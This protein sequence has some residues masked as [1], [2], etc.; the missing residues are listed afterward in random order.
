MQEVISRILDRYRPLQQAIETH[1][2]WP[3]RVEIVPIVISRTGTYNTTTLRQLAHL[4]TLKDEPPDS[5]ITVSS[6]PKEAKQI[7][8]NMHKY[9]KQWL[10]AIL[11]VARHRLRPGQQTQPTDPG[12]ERPRKRQNRRQH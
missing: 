7:A 10:H 11:R 12:A 9:A 2:N 3:H 8:I 6:L 5:G 1:D 4:F